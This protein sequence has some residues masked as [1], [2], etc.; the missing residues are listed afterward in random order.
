MKLVLITAAALLAFEP[1]AAQSPPPGERVQLADLQAEAERVHPAIQAAMRKVEALRSRIPQARALPDPTV[2]FGWMGNV[3]PFD[4]Q[5]GDPSSYRTLSAMQEFPYPGKRKLRGEIATRE[6]A[7]EQWNVEAA[8]RKLRAEVAFAFYGLWV[9]EKS[10]GITRRNKDLLEKLSRIAEEK[11]KVGRGVQQDVLRANV[12]VTR[13]LQRITLLEQQRRTYQ[14]QLNSL[15]LKPLE[16]VVGVEGDLARPQLAYS[17]QELLDQA[18]ASS[19]EVRQQEE[20]IEQSQ[21]AMNLARREYYPDFNTSYMYQ[22]RPGMPDM[23]GF[24]VGIKIP[25]F[26]RDKQ[27]KAVEEISST[28]AGVKQTREAL[29]ISLLFQVKEQFLMAR[30]SEEL[31]TLYAKGIVAQSSLA[32]ESALASYQT[33]EVDFL[34]VITNFVTLLDSE[35]AYYQELGGFYRALTRLEELTGLQL[36]SGPTAA[37]QEV[38]EK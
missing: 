36:A 20:V 26:Y 8:R 11:Y 5:N 38:R 37:V 12:E 18:V 22:Q 35:I 6:V 15:R 28:L 29:R 30:A 7:S 31:L 34:N 14:S 23:H 17:L 4:V 33:G 24:T 27:R 25:V 19:P 2:S 1:S 13:L 3:T 32:L 10:L 16:D 21:V 9:S